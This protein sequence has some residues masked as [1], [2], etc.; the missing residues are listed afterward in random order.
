MYFNC[1]LFFLIVL[2]LMKLEITSKSIQDIISNLI[3]II[4]N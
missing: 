1:I 2:S 4:N 3:F